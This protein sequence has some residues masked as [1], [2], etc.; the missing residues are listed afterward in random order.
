MSEQEPTD[1]VRL[2]DLW[3]GEFG[4]AYIAR[5]RVLDER[6]AAFWARLIAEQPVASVLEV[7]CGQGGNLRPISRLIEPRSVWGIDVNETALAIARRQAPGI[8]AVKGSARS[9]PFPDGFVDLVMTVGVLI[10][11]PDAT[12]PLVLA[13]IVRC[14]HAFVLWAEYHAPR[15]EEVPYHGVPGSLFRRDYG[16]IYR[17]QFPDLVVRDGGFLGPEEGFDRLTWQL[18]EKPGEA[19]S[20]T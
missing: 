7:G 19:R 10:H 5:N 6:R 4:D 17:K 11:Q 15:D 2:E 12:L 3:S 14:S 9:L 18:L 1:A 20:D 16:A 8:P 13:E